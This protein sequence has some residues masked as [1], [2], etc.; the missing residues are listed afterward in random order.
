MGSGIE[1]ARAFNTQT[2]F[3]VLSFSLFRFFLVVCFD[4]SI[5]SFLRREMRCVD[6]VHIIFCHED[7]KIRFM[8]PIGPIGLSLHHQATAALNRPDRW[9]V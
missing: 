9:F 2:C 1:E 6:F 4:D 5:L 7:K 8:K 3:F